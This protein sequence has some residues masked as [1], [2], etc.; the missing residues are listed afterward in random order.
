MYGYGGV[1]ALGAS[2]YALRQLSQIAIASVNAA[3]ERLKSGDVDYSSPSLALQAATRLA[4]KQAAA[5]EAEVRRAASLSPPPAAA[6][7]ASAA[8]NSA[9]HAKRA[10]QHEIATAHAA[11]PQW[12]RSRTDEEGSSG[13][14]ATAVNAPPVFK[15]GDV[16][17]DARALMDHMLSYRTQ[18]DAQRA[19]DIHSASVS[20]ACGGET[21]S[22]SS[23]YGGETPVSHGVAARA[24]ARVA[25]AAPQR[26]AGAS[27][28]S[29]R[30]RGGRSSQSIS[31]GA[32]A[33]KSRSGARKKK[34]KYKG[35]PRPKSKGAGA[36]CNCGCGASFRETFYIVYRK[37][38]QKYE[39]TK[40]RSPKAVKELQQMGKKVRRITFG[41]WHSCLQDA[42]SIRENWDGSQPFDIDFEKTPRGKEAAA[43]EHP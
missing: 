31:G 3:E 22:A 40:K 8:V 32:K 43:N 30:G 36:F 13:G 10:H 41:G 33:K 5:T 38:Q 42:I 4:A 19:A 15:T 16:L 17:R 18:Y 14:G 37:K 26:R 11:Q 35:K 21:A 39:V 1:G 20:S 25:S 12:K 6:S 27:R 34:P 28:P 29:A 23:A 7:S 2:S 9:Q 24:S